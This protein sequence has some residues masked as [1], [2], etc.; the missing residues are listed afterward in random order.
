MT[1]MTADESLTYAHNHAVYKVRTGS[2]LF[3]TTLSTNAPDDD[4][5]GIFVETK[6]EIFK[7]N[8]A[9]TRL[10][11]VKY[12]SA[13]VDPVSGQDAKSAPGDVDGMFYSLHHFMRETAKGNPNTITT[14]FAPDSYV[15]TRTSDNVANE[16]RVNAHRFI[17]KRMGRCYL[18]YVNNQRTQY[19]FDTHLSSKPVMRPALV[20]QHG[21][22]TKGA[23]HALRAALQGIE[24]MDLGHINLPMAEYAREY[25]I[26]VRQGFWNKN[27][28]LSHLTT[29]EAELRDRVR[30]ADWP[31][32]PNHALL[33]HWSQRLHEQYWSHLQVRQDKMW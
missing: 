24:L 3:G 12:R 21:F 7:V 9:H 27:E 31:D 8:P 6:E 13:G 29:L 14:L 16:L 5:I 28:V 1:I 10:K 19:L 25:L 2:Q 26:K 32:E 30:S 22:D 15:L 33:T 20:A 11:T 4:E 23:Y 18:G 17:S